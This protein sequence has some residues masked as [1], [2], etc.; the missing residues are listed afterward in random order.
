ME[1]LTYNELKISEY[2][3]SK[4]LNSMEKKLLFKLRTRMIPVAANFGDKYRPC[5]AC[6]LEPDDQQHLISC[7]MIC[8]SSKAVLFRDST[9]EYNDMFL[10]DTQKLKEVAKIFY[11]ALKTREII[12]SSFSEGLSSTK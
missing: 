4:D 6:L 12:T 1:N 9:V 5:P 2:L 10:R 3:V 8:G 7:F 11:A